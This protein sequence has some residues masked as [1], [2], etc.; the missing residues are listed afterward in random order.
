MTQEE[1]DLFMDLY[2][3]TNTV[4]GGNQEIADIIKEE[5]AAFFDGQKTAEQTAKLI[6]DRVSLYVMEQG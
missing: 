3:R 6:Q 4:T 1:Y 5:C 2:Q